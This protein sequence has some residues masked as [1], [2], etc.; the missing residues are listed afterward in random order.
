MGMER[1]DKTAI[2]G[3]FIGLGAAVAGVAAAFA[4][5]SVSLAIWRGIFFCGVFGVI[6]SLLA[7]LDLHVLKGVNRVLRCAIHASFIIIYLCSVG[8]SY[9]SLVPGHLIARFTF[10]NPPEIWMQKAV[11]TKVII[12]NGSDSGVIFSRIAVVE[13][14]TNAKI[15]NP[16]DALN[17]C[18]DPRA[19][20]G[21]TM[22]SF[23]PR[24]SVP[25]IIGDTPIGS[26]SAHDLVIST[27]N[28][29][30]PNGD[31]VLS[32]DSAIG[33]VGQFQIF[34]PNWDHFNAVV[35]CPSV[36]IENAVTGPRAFVC[37][38]ILDFRFLESDKANIAQSAS[39]IRTMWVEHRQSGVGEL[40]AS[41]DGGFILK[42]DSRADCFVGTP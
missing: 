16:Y 23:N 34:P 25:I 37:K 7:L 33:V 38:G 31:V 28:G 20:L 4:F 9:L 36:T 13:I 19:F 8:W 14:M 29:E 11:S 10:T 26:L 2:W 22:D 32:K 17:L 1:G 15:Y 6:I 39:G 27:V 30:K 24:G 12:S 42:E 18:T 5:T 3:I 21:L 35:L 40:M 41:I